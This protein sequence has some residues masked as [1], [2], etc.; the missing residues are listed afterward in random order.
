MTPMTH[1]GKTITSQSLTRT[2]AFSRDQQ[3]AHDTRKGLVQRCSFGNAMVR[4]VQPCS[5]VCLSS[6]SRAL[7]HSRWVSCKGGRE[8]RN[9]GPRDSKLCAWLYGVHSKEKYSTPS[10]PLANQPKRCLKLVQPRLIGYA[11]MASDKASAVSRGHSPASAQ[12][13]S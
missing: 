1:A 5:A 11:D 10:T 7:A 9:L 6:G 3:V 2:S 13:L 12:S 8:F 4:P